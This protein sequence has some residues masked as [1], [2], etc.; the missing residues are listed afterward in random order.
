MRVDLT[1]TAASQISSESNTKRVGVGSAATTGLSSSEDR[2]TLTSD[3][4]SLSSLVGTAMK[5]P[6]IREDKVASL[7]Q[8]IESGQYKLDPSAIAS[9]MIDEHA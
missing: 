5:S 8:A 9:S 6:E 3:S 2:T 7:K 4:T 1:Q